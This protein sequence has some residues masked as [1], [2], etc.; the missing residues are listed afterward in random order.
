MAKTDHSRRRLLQGALA[1]IGVQVALPTLDFMLNPHGTALAQGQPLPKRFLLWFYGCGVLLKRWVPTTTGAGWALSEQLMP[2]ADVKDYLNIVTG[3]DVTFA[4]DSH[5]TGGIAQRT[6]MD[7]TEDKAGEQST[8]KGPSVDQIA[9]QAIAGTTRF[10]SLQLGVLR[11]NQTGEGDGV[12]YASHNGPNSPNP[13][14]LDPA[15]V[16]NRVFGAGFAPPSGAAPTPSQPAPADLTLEL[17]KSVLDAVLLDV[18]TLKPRLGSQDLA[19]LDQHAT[20][21]REIE[22]RLIPAASPVTAGVGCSQLSAPMSYGSVLGVDAYVAVNKL[23]SDLTVMALA[24]DQTRSI[25]YQFCGVGNHDVFEVFTGTSEDYHTLG[26]NGDEVNVNKIIIFIMQQLAYL[27]SALKATPEGAGNLLDQSAL[28]ALTEIAEGA[29][30]EIND[31]PILLAGKAGGALRYPGVHY[32][33]TSGEVATI[34]ILSALRAVGVPMSSFGEGVM[35]T[36]QGLSQI[37]A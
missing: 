32:R 17:R 19:R 6:G 36:S 29:S 31:M 14:E 27:L 24:C 18:D 4:N 20:N 21:I 26:H 15:K 5:H 9:A 16:F 3:T 13:S 12:L 8:V 7:R 1:G 34:P 25:A 11:T 10:A 23:M 22:K 33:S 28:L 2:F 37:E 30:H 35:Q